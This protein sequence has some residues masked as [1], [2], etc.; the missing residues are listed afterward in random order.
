[1]THAMLHLWWQITYTFIS[2]E[3]EEERCGISVHKI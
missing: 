3:E 1:M 2:D